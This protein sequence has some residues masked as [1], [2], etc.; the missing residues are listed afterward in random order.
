MIKRPPAPKSLAECLADLPKNHGYWEDEARYMSL[1]K[2]LDGQGRYLPFADLRYR[3]PKGLD[4]NLCW[5]I[6]RSARVESQAPIMPSDI[7]GKQCFWFQTPALLQAI[8]KVNE[9]DML[10]PFN[11]S[12]LE[13]D[14]SSKI[15]RLMR[16]EA[17]HSSQLEGAST[18]TKNAEEMLKRNRKP[19]NES[20]RMIDGNYRLM[21]SAWQMRNHPATVEL[22]E[23]FHSSGMGE[24]D[25]VKYSPGCF[26]SGNDVV[27]QDGDGNVVHTPPE[28]SGIIG[29]LES[30]MEWINEPHLALHPLVKACALHF[31]IGYEHPFR[32]GNGRVARALFYWF[33]FKSG[34]KSFLYISI[35]EKILVAPQKYGQSYVYTETDEMDLT[36]FLDYQAKIISNAIDSYSSATT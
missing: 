5:A 32:D 35:S 21:R 8:E 12:P 25:D 7:F 19:L 24:I 26:R 16:S 22:I 3:W 6:V 11:S 14:S 31:A 1:N 4:G 15:A 33:M 30:L 34:Y 20:E 29:R 18:S 36:Y 28:A 17:I 27:V 23:A 2:P 13:L 9:V 10:E